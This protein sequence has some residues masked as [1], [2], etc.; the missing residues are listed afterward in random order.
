VEISYIAAT[1]VEEVAL[2]STVPFGD[3]KRYPTYST[4]SGCG[5]EKVA[6]TV[7]V[8]VLIVVPALGT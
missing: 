6:P 3:I 1:S 2:K 8:P 5:I 4:N 7:V